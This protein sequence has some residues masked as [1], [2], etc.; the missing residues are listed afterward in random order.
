M[1][2]RTKDEL[3][4]K[5][6]KVADN[7]ATAFAGVES[8]IIVN[9]DNASGDIEIDM[10][11]HFIVS[12]EDEGDKMNISYATAKS[13]IKNATIAQ[14]EKACVLMNRI[15]KASLNGMNMQNGEAQRA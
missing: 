14:Q 11:V 10:S 15:I 1:T 2:E 4:A 9:R 13:F 7:D 8:D 12:D 6:K 5:I 3:L